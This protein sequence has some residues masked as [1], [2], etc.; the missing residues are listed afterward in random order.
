MCH[1]SN[2][3]DERQCKCRYNH[4]CRDRKQHADIANGVSLCAVT[5]HQRSQRMK[6]L[7]DCRVYNG[8]HQ[9]VCQKCI[10]NL[11]RV[12]KRRH[13]K[14]ENSCYCV[15]YCQSQ[16]PDTSLTIFGVRAVNNRTHQ[17]IRE[18]IKNTRQQQNHTNRTDGNTYNVRVKVGE[19]G[20]GDCIYE[21]Q[22]R[23]T[24]AICQFFRHRYFDKL[25]HILVFLL[26]IKQ[27]CYTAFMTF[28]ISH[29]GYIRLF[30]NYSLPLHACFL[31]GWKTL[32]I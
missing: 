24:K 22:C 5:A 7:A 32:W 17:D 28:G 27:F 31:Q 10:D 29:A 9:I 1:V 4:A 25:V 30:H 15:R 11:A 14:Q 12:A 21:R 19:K 20:S 13:G 16:N 26:K 23:I 18:S 2:F 6:W 3:I 8:V